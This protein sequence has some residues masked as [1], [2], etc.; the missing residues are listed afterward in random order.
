M[1]DAP[2][3]LDASALLALLFAE[4][5][6]ERVEPLLASAVIG[7][8]NLSEVIAKLVDR[9]LT[10]ASALTGL[11]DLGLDV[12]PHDRAQAER[13]GA[14]RAQ[15]TGLNLSLGDRAC[16]ALAQLTGA[17]A[18]TADRAWLKAGKRLGI[19][20]ILVR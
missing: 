20:V 10:P 5:G 3:V 19:G 11:R 8:V 14:I 15:L 7:A 2:P 4:T 6:A 12:V 18:V 13:A 9:G 16:L 17:E 1:A